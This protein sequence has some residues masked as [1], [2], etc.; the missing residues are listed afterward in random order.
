MAYEQSA[1][2][3]YRCRGP[4]FET[5]SYLQNQERGQHRNCFL[6]SA[7]APPPF[8]K[9]HGLPAEQTCLT[10]VP[11]VIFKQ[12]LHLGSLRLSA[13]AEIHHDPNQ[14]HHHET[15]QRKDHQGHGNRCE[16]KHAG[17]AVSESH[18]QPAQP[19]RHAEDDRENRDD[20]G[21]IDPATHAPAHSWL[22][23][24]AAHPS[25]TAKP[26]QPALPDTSTGSHSSHPA[27]AVASGNRQPSATRDNWRGRCGS[28]SP[29]EA[30]RSG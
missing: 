20:L 9:G 22:R 1:Q 7:P 15:A 12:L 30:G 13:T 3:G 24:V 5:H 28:A 2:Q 11:L 6:P 27:A 21:E 16:G 14:T 26:A 18:R 29:P 25:P 8:A 10:L 17:N 23:R 19:K 4:C